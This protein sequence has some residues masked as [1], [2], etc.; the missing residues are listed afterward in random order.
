MIACLSIS[1]TACGGGGGGGSSAA[2]P[3]A[4]DDGGDNSG[5]GSGGGSDDGSG[6]GSDDGS[7]GG[8]G[9]DLNPGISGK[10]FFI[11]DN[12]A[13]FM[14][15]SSGTYELVPNSDWEAQ[16]DKFE[17]G[18]AEY[19]AKPF[20]AESQFLLTVDNCVNRANSFAEDA[21]VIVQDFGGNYGAEIILEDSVHGPA[22]PSYDG[23][24]FA[25]F[26]DLGDDWLAIYDMAG[27]F[28]SNTQVDEAP[29]AWLADGRLVYVADER[30][31]RIT[32]TLSTS[33]GSAWTL[34]DGMGSGEIGRL[35]V[36]PDGSQIAFTLRTDGSLVS[37]DASFWMITVATGSIRRIAEVNDG[38]LEDAFHESAWSPDGSMIAVLEGGSGSVDPNTGLG[39][40]TRMHLLPSDAS[41]VLVIS[42]DSALQSSEVITLRRY[43]DIEQPVGNDNP[44]ETGFPNIRFDWLT[45]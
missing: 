26:R 22:K 12:Q 1:I 45:E 33:G 23:Q 3:P 19:Y 32:D 44:S 29:F 5:G 43:R 15:I 20:N 25:V 31:F 13:W 38:G 21:C 27:N 30:T 34:P 42:S 28:V 6:G 10:L 17:L 18:I 24:Y 39:A 41:E 4:S 11:E 40:E 7:G 37:E 35:S 36:S 14:D 2:P 8:S 16:D 9:N